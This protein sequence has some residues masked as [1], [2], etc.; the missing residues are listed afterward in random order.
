LTTVTILMLTAFGCGPKK[1]DSLADFKGSKIG[2]L[3]GTIFVDFVDRVIPNVEHFT[4]KSMKGVEGII[5]NDRVDAICVD[6]PVGKYFVAQNPGFV[7]FPTMLAEDRYGFAVS[8]GS[9]LY[10][11]AQDIIVRLRKEGTIKELEDTWFTYAGKKK[12]LLDYKKDFDGSAGTIKYACENSQP[13]MSY[14]GTN[15]KPVGLDLDVMNAIAYEMNM[16]IEFIPMEFA[17]L[18]PSIDSGKADMAGGSMSI[19]AERLDKYDFV[20]PYMYGGVVLVIKR[21]RLG[22]RFL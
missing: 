7:V 5:K 21:D 3:E 17:S 19:T 14:L 10:E 6:M 16:K 1:F 20:G 8:K 15:G 11:Q 18:L 13:P 4:F 9:K 22:K 2:S 12:L